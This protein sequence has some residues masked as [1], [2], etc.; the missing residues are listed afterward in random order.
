M[1]DTK[2]VLASII[3]GLPSSHC[4]RNGSKDRFFLYA[5]SVSSAWALLLFR[6]SCHLTTSR[7]YL[8]AISKESLK[9]QTA[10]RHRRRQFGLGDAVRP[11]TRR[12]VSI[13]SVKNATPAF[14]CQSLSILLRRGIH[15]IIRVPPCVPLEARAELSTAYLANAS[16]LTTLNFKPL[17]F[18]I[19]CR[20]VQP[21]EMLQVP[22]RVLLAA[23]D[24]VG[25]RGRV[26]AWA[27]VEQSGPQPRLQRAEDGAPEAKM[28][29]IVKKGRINDNHSNN[30]N[31][32]NKRQQ[33]RRANPLPPDAGVIKADPGSKQNCC[34]FETNG[35][36]RCCRSERRGTQWQEGQ[37]FRGRG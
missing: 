33:A 22:L 10:E 4:S 25:R 29:D 11:S 15:V 30:D 2:N 27:L 31:N 21:H 14:L 20:W 32:D 24:G 5:L 16:L 6:Y 36:E 35:T 3:G 19:A 7:N 8:A 13:N 26:S 28:H 12:A 37:N 9:R 23:L 18:S 1:C 17:P 34:A